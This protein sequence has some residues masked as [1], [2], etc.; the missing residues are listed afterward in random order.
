MEVVEA[1]SAF[2]KIKVGLE[3]AIAF[4]EGDTSRGVVHVPAE[5]DVKAIRKSLK[6]SQAEFAACY[7]FGLPRLRDWEQ[8]RSRPD[9]A[10]R[11]YLIVI[12]REHEAVDR[13]LRAA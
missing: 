6:L 10:S 12:E 5:V 9:S 2:E 1:M 3:D 13:A 11:A 7:G 8:G 4:A